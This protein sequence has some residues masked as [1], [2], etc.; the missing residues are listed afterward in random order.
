MGR[1]DAFLAAEMSAEFRGGKKRRDVALP[2][3]PGP[4]VQ[5]MVCGRNLRLMYA[6]LHSCSAFSFLEG[7]SLPEDIIGEAARLEIPAIALLDRDGVY[8][9]PR[10]HMAARKAGVRA[11]VGAE[12]SVAELGNQ[13]EF[14]HGCRTSF[15][16]SPCGWRF[17]RRTGPDTRTCAV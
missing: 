17:W 14:L 9:A 11:H 16:P 7:A 10:F 1:A 4:A 13:V 12:I 6:E 3:L 15:R 5:A 2:N 8:G